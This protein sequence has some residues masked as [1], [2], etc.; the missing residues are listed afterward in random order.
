MVIGREREFEG[1]EVAL[2]L[3]MNGLPAG[4]AGDNG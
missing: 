1:E 4:L 2:G 3:I